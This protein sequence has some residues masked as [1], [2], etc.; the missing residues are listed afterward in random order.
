MIFT[1]PISSYSIAPLRIPMSRFR[2]QS[3]SRP[4]RLLLS[5][6]YI[7][8][9]NSWLCCWSFSCAGYGVRSCPGKRCR[10]IHQLSQY[11]SPGIT[12]RIGQSFNMIPASPRSAMYNGQHHTITHTSENLFRLMD[13]AELLDSS[14]AALYPNTPHIR[15]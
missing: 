2:G 6:H 5:C 11:R 1:S 13:N 3:A 10:R 7:H 8:D 12:L 14:W 4:N 9:A 15:R